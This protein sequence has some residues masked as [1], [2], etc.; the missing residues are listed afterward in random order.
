MGYRNATATVNTVAT[1]PAG[2]EIAEPRLGRRISIYI[3]NTSA[4]AEKINVFFTDAF[5][6]T[7]AAAVGG[8]ALGPGEFIIDSKSEGYDCWQGRIIA[9]SDTDAAT[10]AIAERVE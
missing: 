3:K 9:V 7:L 1:T 5:D 10:V 6:T 4:A 2:A 8:Y